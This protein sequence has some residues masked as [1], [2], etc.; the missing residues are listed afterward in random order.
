MTTTPAADPPRQLTREHF[1]LLIGGLLTTAV[2]QSFIFAILPPLGR[3]VGFNEMQ[4]NAM[5]STS[6]MIFSL[7]TPWWGRFSDRVGRKP[8]LVFGLAAYAVG[9]F[10]FALVL[11][12]GMR[13][14]L[15][16]M[17]LFAIA[18]LARC[19][20]A[21]TM[22]ASNPA[23][24]AYTADF[25]GPKERTKA[26]ARLGTASSLGMI[27]GPIIAGALA[28]LGLLFP[29]FVATGLAALAALI[30][31]IRLPT[32]RNPHREHRAHRKLKLTDSRLSMYLLCSFGAFVGFSG[33]QQTLAFRLQDMFT[34]S[35]AETAQ[36]T[37]VAM[38][39][40]AFFTLLMQLTVTQRFQGPPVMLIRIGLALMAVGALLISI[41][42]SYALIVIALGI[43]GAGLGLA[44]PSLAAAASLAVEPE[45]QGATAGLVTAC[46]AAGFVVGPVFFG[47]LYTLDPTVSAVGAGLMLAIVAATGWLGLKRASQSVS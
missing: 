25:S 38:M 10:I 15:V 31:A 9:N 22:S 17:P 45:E 19:T 43:V 46:P 47:W 29:L 42:G 20:Q 11:S 2:G 5:I 27:F 12:A 37:G 13:G 7:S 16:G 18:L 36:H 34:L 3:D 28:G 41:A 1:A 21:I 33:I 40:T 14:V 24:A 44:T 39:T 26:M 35:G 23:A 32:D 6:A 4:I 8:V 30:V